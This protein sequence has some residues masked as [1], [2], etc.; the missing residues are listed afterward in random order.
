MAGKANIRRFF[1][2]STLGRIRL[3]S[4]LRGWGVIATILFIIIGSVATAWAQTKPTITVVAVPTTAAKGAQVTVQINVKDFPSS[5]SGLTAM[6]GT[7]RWSPAAALSPVLDSSGQGIVCTAKAPFRMDSASCS[8]NANAG[9]AI[10]RV[11][12]SAPTTPFTEGTVIEFKFTVSTSATDGQAVSLS[13]QPGQNI[14]IVITNRPLP[15]SEFTL[16]SGTFTVGTTT[17]TCTYSLSGFTSNTTTVRSGE[18]V[19]FN[20]SATRNT[21]CTQFPTIVLS[22]GDGQSQTIQNT[23][24]QSVAH[25]YTNTSSSAIT[26]TATLTLN[27]QSAG[28]PITITVNPP[29]CK[30]TNIDF[31]V[32]PVKPVVNKKITFRGTGTPCTSGGSLTFSWT[33]GDSTTGTG[34]TFEKTYTRASTGSGFSVTLTVRDSGGGTET[35]TKSVLVVDRPSCE[36]LRCSLTNSSSTRRKITNFARENV[37]PFDNVWEKTNQGINNPS[38]GLIEKLIELAEMMAGDSKDTFEEIIG[39]VSGVVEAIREGVEAAVEAGDVSTSRARNI[40]DQIDRFQTYLD[41]VMPDQMDIID[42]SLTDLVSAYEEARDALDDGD[43]TLAVDALFQAR[44]HVAKA[45]QSVN[46]VLT[47]VLGN[48]TKISR[49]VLAAERLSRRRG[50]GGGISA[51]TLGHLTL[52]HTSDGSIV[53]RAIGTE[54]IGVELYSLDGRIAFRD[55]AQGAELKLSSGQTPANGVYLAHVTAI[56]ADGTPSARLFKL[57]LMR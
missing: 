48:L 26:V 21:G 23:L 43:S 22:F 38:R 52:S 39:D 20:V 3:F 8:V 25:T 37:F 19:T 42:E 16:Q 47:A 40:I 33:F 13:L 18:S 28:S 51:L 34:A 45:R 14:L 17:T 49:S 35:R 15:Q 50:S 4:Q 10:F 54:A 46:A 1:S 44:S 55:Q 27:G 2:M 41:E 30:P 11:T 56:A 36:S 29:P 24:S 32:N 6:Q 12:N 31:S 57:V 5:P 9:Q 53:F 7:L